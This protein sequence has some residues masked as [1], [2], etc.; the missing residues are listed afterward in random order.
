[1][2]FVATVKDRITGHIV[3]VVTN[4]WDE[5]VKWA[6]NRTEDGLAVIRDQRTGQQYWL[7]LS[8]ERVAWVYA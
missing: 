1:M 6:R 7:T 5:A 8:D 3:T 2:Q 4:H